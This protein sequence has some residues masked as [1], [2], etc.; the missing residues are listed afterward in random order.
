MTIAESENS[1]SSKSIA[2]VLERFIDDLYPLLVVAGDLVIKEREVFVWCSMLNELASS[3]QGGGR[4]EIYKID[5]DGNL[6]IPEL[7]LATE[8][9][10]DDVFLKEKLNQYLPLIRRAALDLRLRP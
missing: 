4:V 8:G 9:N 1:R 7:Y 5:Y 10:V 2:V 3:A 6:S